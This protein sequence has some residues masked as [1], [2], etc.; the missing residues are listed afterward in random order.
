[1]FCMIASFNFNLAD[2]A[3]LEQAERHYLDH[4]YPVDSERP[5]A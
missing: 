5:H 4:A 3:S 2:F 1:M